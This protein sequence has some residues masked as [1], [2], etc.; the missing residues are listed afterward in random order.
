M[1]SAQFKRTAPIAQQFDH[2]LIERFEARQ[3]LHQMLLMAGLV[4]VVLSVATLV[5]ESVPLWVLAITLPVLIS[6][7]FTNRLGWRCLAC[8]GR[9]GLRMSVRR[10]PHCG[11]KL[12]ARRLRK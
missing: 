9:L 10:C 7:T 3:R 8:D 4:M 1:P 5:L 11:E 6:I 2:R 12:T